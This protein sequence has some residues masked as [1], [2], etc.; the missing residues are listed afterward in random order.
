MLFFCQD[1]N[2]DFPLDVVDK[3][4]APMSQEKV[5][6]EGSCGGRQ[7][8]LPELWT[9]D[10]GGQTAAS[11]LC[12]PSH[13]T[14]CT[15]REDDRRAS[16]SVISSYVDTEQKPSKKSCLAG[17]AELYG[18]QSSRTPSG[19]DQAMS[20]K[21][22]T[23]EGDVPS[24]EDSYS[25]EILKKRKSMLRAKMS[26]LMIYERPSPLPRLCCGSSPSTGREFKSPHSKKS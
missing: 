3:I 23:N 5:R 19:E 12:N 21:T 11:G 25:S 15:E 18:N 22:H 4:F 9:R 14:H 20:E 13:V 7:A 1:Y 6:D 26:K 24:V 10:H 17:K 16:D 2:E 8:T